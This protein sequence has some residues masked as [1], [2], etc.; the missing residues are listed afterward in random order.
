MEK[1]YVELS[2]DEELKWREIHQVEPQSYKQRCEYC[3]KP[4]YQILKPPNEIDVEIW[5]WTMKCWKCQKNTQ[6]VWPNKESSGFY[7]ESLSPQSFIN[8]PQVIHEFF[9]FFKITEKK[10]QDVIEFGNTCTH[11][12]VYQGDWFVVEELLEI[13][14][15]P[16]LAKK[17]QIHIQITK[18]E[19]L[20][21]SN[22]KKVLKMHSPR[23]GLYSSLCESCFAL[24]KKKKI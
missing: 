1:N 24:Y 2:P 10:T 19:Q 23:K 4:V 5:T 9:P 15:E 7:W 21:F 11:C 12:G 6:V 18:E 16:Y 22:P 8:L 20:Y 14:Y 17:H 3:Q 13:S